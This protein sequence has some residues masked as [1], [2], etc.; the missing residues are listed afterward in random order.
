MAIRAG[1]VDQLRVSGVSTAVKVA[2]VP[3]ESSMP[4]TLSRVERRTAS[5]ATILAIIGI[6]AARATA[7]GT[8]A[9]APAGIAGGIGAFACVIGVAGIAMLV[10]GIIYLRLLIRLRRA[11]RE[12]AALAR[13]TWAAG[14]ATQTA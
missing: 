6:M 10:F 1:S 8:G 9:G 3:R 13:A 4:T 2:W 5:P 14:G 12:Q 11:F 7:T